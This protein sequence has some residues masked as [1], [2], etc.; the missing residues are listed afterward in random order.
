MEIGLRKN[1]RGRI[2]PLIAPYH[3]NAFKLRLGNDVVL[4]ETLIKMLFQCRFSGKHIRKGVVLEVGVNQ[5]HLLVIEA[6]GV[7]KG[8]QQECFAFLFPR[9][10]DKKTFGIGGFYFKPYLSYQLLKL[11]KLRAFRLIVKN[12]FEVD[13][14]EVN[15]KVEADEIDLVQVADKP[16]VGEFFKLGWGLY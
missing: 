4:H 9:A 7:G 10:G 2:I 14:N 11:F 8:N 13:V 12:I 6:Q 15:I 5:Q 1:F 3:V 16:E